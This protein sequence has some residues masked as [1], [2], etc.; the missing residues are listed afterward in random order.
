M[1]LYIAIFIATLLRFWHLGVRPFDGDEGVILWQATQPSFREF[2][3]AIARDAHPPLF[4]LF[5]WLGTRIFGESELGLRFFPAV[6]GVLLVPASF[7]LAREILG[8]RQALLVAWFVA[9]AP[10]LVAFSQEARMYSLLALVVVMSLWTIVK[11]KQLPTVVFTA[12]AIYSH[13]LGLLLV[14]LI[15]LRRYWKSLAGLVLLTAP[16]VPLALPQFIGRLQE[17]GGLNLA[18]NLKGLVNAFY[19]FGAGR[20]FLGLELNP[21]NQL[22][23]LRANP[24]SWFVFVLTLIIPAILFFYG[25]GRNVREK[26]WLPVWLFGGL[27]VIAALLSSE[28]GS[29]AARNLSFLAP[30]YFIVLTAAIF[31]LK[32][33]A[34]LTATVLVVAILGLGLTQHHFK[35]LR[36]P[37]VDAVVAEIGKTNADNAAVLARGAFLKGESTIFNYY[38]Q[39]QFPDREPP[40]AV[41]YFGEYRIGNLKQLREQSVQ[42]LVNDLLKEHPTVFFYDFSYAPHDLTA[43]PTILGNDKEDKAIALRRVDR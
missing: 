3:A 24:L 11:G 40:L 23:W 26:Q 35:E 22:D 4:H 41:D 10:F 16:L 12:L 32:R 33:A 37:G 6:F 9:L 21:Q 5:S 43:Q 2:W 1:S 34:K 13:Y 7:L 14:P 29:R 18:A 19:R 27:A 30:L 17:A 39:K 15:I 36:R 42:K 8:K 25:V 38:W 20:T 28:V 31:D